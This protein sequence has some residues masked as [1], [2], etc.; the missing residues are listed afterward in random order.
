MLFVSE[1]RCEEPV[2]KENA[3]LSM[4]SYSS[5][6]IGVMC[7]IYIVPAEDWVS[8]ISQGVKSSMFIC[9]ITAK[10]YVPYTNEAGNTQ[11]FLR[12]GFCFHFR[13]FI[14]SLTLTLLGAT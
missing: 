4:V 9:T 10:T 8:L 3:K 6:S 2:C 11:E 5:P 14:K 1:K 7:L 13:D 12:V